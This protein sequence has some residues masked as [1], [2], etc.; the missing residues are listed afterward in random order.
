MVLSVGPLVGG[1]AKPQDMHRILDSE[2]GDYVIAGFGIT[3]NA[4]TSTAINIAVGSAMLNGFYIAEDAVA[5]VNTPNASSR[6]YLFIQLT[7]NGADEP[8]AVAYLVTSAE[9]TA[10]SIRLAQ[11]DGGTGGT[12]VGSI[13]IQFSMMGFSNKQHAIYQT[14]AVFG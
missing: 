2:T 7:L 4:T 13:F 8:T 9:T 6:G 1:T 5:S 3:T 14:Q 11:L 12:T 10:N